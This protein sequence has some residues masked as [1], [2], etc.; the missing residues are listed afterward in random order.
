MTQS[1]VESANAILAGEPVQ[2]FHE[3][4]I[5]EV[6]HEWY[7]TLTENQQIEVNVLIEMD[8]EVWHLTPDEFAEAL[9][10][11]VGDNVL[12]EE[13]ESDDDKKDPTKHKQGG[14][15]GFAKRNLSKAGR[16]AEKIRKLDKDTK[17]RE[18][19]Q[20]KQKTQADLDA[21]LAAAKQKNEPLKQDKSTDS[22]G[23]KAAR[24]VGSKLKSAGS[25]AK[26]WL[27]HGSGKKKPSAGDVMQRSKD[28]KDAKATPEPA[29]TTSGSNTP[30]TPPKTDTPK[31]TA[32]DGGKKDTP[33]P[34]KKTD[35]AVAKLGGDPPKK[36]KT[37]T[38]APAGLESKHWDQWKKS[39]I[40]DSHDLSV[41]YDVLAGKRTK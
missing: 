15:L 24:A 18:G 2:S 34:E 26:N 5:E 22:A 17:K 1:L 10:W 30:S 28:Q 6:A 25:A 31:L 27:L 9:Q 41:Y 23:K 21:R 32:H 36:K 14:L 19:R 16:T 39:G 13:E 4:L 33:P 29:K 20:A 3:T 38:A 8:E 37:G 11:I 12:Y 40:Q 7:Y 35:P